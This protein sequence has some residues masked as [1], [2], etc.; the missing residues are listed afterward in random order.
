MKPWE[1]EWRIGHAPCEVFW[2]AGERAGIVADGLTLPAS[3]ARLIAAAPELYRALEA[4]VRWHTKE[5]CADDVPGNLLT[6]AEVA[7]KKARGE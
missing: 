3:R 1:E 5:S 4:L 6:A 7:M 2:R